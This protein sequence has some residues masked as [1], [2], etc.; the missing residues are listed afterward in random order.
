MAALLALNA[1]M[2]AVMF[3]MGYSDADEL[4]V[5]LDQAW[6]FLNSGSLC[7][8]WLLTAEAFGNRS[9]Y[10]VSQVPWRINIYIGLYTNCR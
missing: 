1:A 9:R 10:H 3:G 2:C 6:V 8:L 5:T 7:V 4:A